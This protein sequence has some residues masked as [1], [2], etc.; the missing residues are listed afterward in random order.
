MF[1]WFSTLVTHRNSVTWQL[2]CCWRLRANSY[3]LLSP[4]FKH[5]AFNDRGCP[6]V[7]RDIS[8]KC[9]KSKPYRWQ[10]TVSIYN[11][12]ALYCTLYITW[13]TCIKPT[14]LQGR[15]DCH[16]HFTVGAS[17]GVQLVK[18]LSAM[19]IWIPSLAS[20]LLHYSHNY[21]FNSLF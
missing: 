18:N 5:T 17:L 21:S 3:R 9:Y 10:C 2:N 4:S 8:I 12:K 11:M 1:A 7:A 15:S 20:V 6:L 16:P 14:T 19:Q 13:F